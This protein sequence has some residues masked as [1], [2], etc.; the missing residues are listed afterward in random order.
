MS[1]INQ[2]RINK[3][4]QIRGKT[5]QKDFAM[6]IDMNPSYYCRLESG[7]TPISDKTMKRIARQ[8]NVMYSVLVDDSIPEIGPMHFEVVEDISPLTKELHERKTF[9]K[10]AHQLL[11]EIIAYGGS[12]NLQ[13]M[14][15]LN[16]FL[17]EVQYLL[18]YKDQF[19][20]LGEN[21]EK[22]IDEGQKLI[23]ILL[24]MS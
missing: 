24:G 7:A 4:L 17:L 1:E 11:D 6:S 8:Y 2:I 16:S 21:E 5:S 19:D 22:V 18:Q 14:K 13:Y 23:D 15:D 9:S 3:L 12:D 10:H 20:D